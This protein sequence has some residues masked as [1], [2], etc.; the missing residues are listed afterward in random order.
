VR[1]LAA[2]LRRASFRPPDEDEQRHLTATLIGEGFDPADLS[3]NGATTPQALWMRLVTLVR[4]LDTWEADGQLQE[5][6]LRCPGEIGSLRERYE[7]ILPKA[8]RCFSLSRELAAGTPDR[9]AAAALGAYREDV[10]NQIDALLRCLYDTISRAVLLCELTHHRRVCRLLGLGFDVHAEPIRHISL[11][12]LMLLFTAGS[13]LFT[14]MFVVSPRPGEGTV[15][16]LLRSG[17]TAAIYCVALWCAIT[18]KRLWSVARRRPENGRP[19]A[20]YLASAAAAALAGAG[21]NF[22]TKLL[23]LGNL[24]T[25]WERFCES[26]TWA[27]MTFAVAYAVAVLADD[28]PADFAVLG[29]LGRRLWLVEA[30]LMVAT[31]LPVMLFIYRLL[32]DTMSPERIP[33]L[34]VVLPST[35]VAAFAI[36]ALVPSWY[37]DSPRSTR[38]PRLIAAPAAAAAD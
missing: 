37:R 7:E 2:E 5:Y 9:H 36:G 26:M 34:S 19:W 11:N 3:F 31:M 13:V 20:A 16:L 1:R 30:L 29:L 32:R 27:I 38:N 23:S 8:R 33:L 15:D 12:S 6:F 21:V 35:A 24:A 25:T 10:A 14:L 18:P 28:E 4:R 17:M 22:V